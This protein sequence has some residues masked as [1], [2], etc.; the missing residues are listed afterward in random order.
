MIR[1]PIKRR[2]KVK[3]QKSNINSR[4]LTF[5]QYHF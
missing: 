4:F 3:G 2:L 5:F 1:A